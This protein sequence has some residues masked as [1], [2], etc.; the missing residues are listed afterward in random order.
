[1][2]HP[3]F[4]LPAKIQYCLFL[5]DY[6]WKNT[7]FT[8]NAFLLMI[9]PI[10][11][12]I[13]KIYPEKEKP[14]N[15]GTGIDQIRKLVISV[16]VLFWLILLLLI[17]LILDQILRKKGKKNDEHPW[18]KENKYSVEFQSSRSRTGHSTLYG[19]INENYLCKNWPSG[20]ISRSKTGSCSYRYYLKWT[21]TQCIPEIVKIRRI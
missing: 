7:L 17:L 11:I 14:K 2:F 6:L 20:R 8:E 3:W 4:T 15:L 21:V 10:T 18:F 1:M 16:P 5:S 12:E 13:K 9:P 19:K